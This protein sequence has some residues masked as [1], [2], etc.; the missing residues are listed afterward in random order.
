MKSKGMAKDKFTHTAQARLGLCSI[1]QTAEPLNLGQGSEVSESDGTQDEWE[2][3]K[4]CQGVSA[5]TKGP[6]SV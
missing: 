5:V 2:E 1:Q 4:K 3:R 6:N